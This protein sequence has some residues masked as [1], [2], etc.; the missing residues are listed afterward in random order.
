[1]RSRYVVW[2]SICVTLAGCSSKRPP[3]VAPPPAVDLTPADTLTQAGCYRCLKEAYEVYERVRTS[4][5]PTARARDGAF[6]TAVLLALREKDLDLEATPWLV[7]ARALATP[8]EAPYVD[9]VAAL[10]WDG[11]TPP[12]FAPERPMPPDA[13]ARWRTTPPTIHPE[14]DTYLR[15]T[16]ECRLGTR[17]TF[18]DT[19]R[20]VDLN[21]PLLQYAA[22]LCGPE[23]RPLLEQLVAH[24]ARFAEAWYFIG[25]YEMASGVIA[26]GQA[27]ARRWLTTSV[28]PLSDAHAALPEVPTIT[29]VLA[30]LMRA[31]NDLRRALALY[32]EALALR[33]SHG[34]ALFG[35]LVTL[36]YLRQQQDQAIAAATA[37]INRNH[38]HV[39]SAFY[40]R[41]WNEYQKDQFNEAARDIATAKQMRAQEEVQI[42]SG[43]VAYAQARKADA[44]ADF[45]A[46]IA[47]NASRCVA[48]WYL[49]LLNLDDEA[50]SPAAQ[51]FSDAAGCYV[52]TAERIRQE[53]GQLLDDLPEDVRREQ[54]AGY[55][56]AI[57]ENVKQAGRSFFNAA[58]AAVRLGDTPTALRQARAALAYEDVRERAEAI[59]KRLEH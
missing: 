40:Y 53:A 46:A 18:S 47:G 39:P 34:E 13:L 55:Q 36:S 24:D 57:A 44:R 30:G 32:D 56:E 21:A 48:H 59:V 1:V 26:V 15:L 6:V 5:A 33:P 35:R 28:K 10:P 22:G 11:G 2:L 58:Q 9:V 38:G 41:A 45:T 54:L 37:I 4:P 52:A 12:D 19:L 16:L 17:A 51:T 20:Q 25:R 14:L 49:G 8:D 7:R 23:R 31:R 27:G 3:V 42:V 29:S 50:W 43:M